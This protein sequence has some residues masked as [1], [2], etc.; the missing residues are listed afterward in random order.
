MKLFVQLAIIAAFATPVFANTAEK[1]VSEPTA[2]V[3]AKEKKKK[4][5]KEE[6]KEEKKDA[7]APA[8]APAA[9]K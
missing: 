3:V 2:K 8:E 5:K 1:A 6:G 7:A 4:K 9:G